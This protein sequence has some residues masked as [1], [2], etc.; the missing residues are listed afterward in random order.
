MLGMFRNSIEAN[1]SLVAGGV[2]VRRKL[3]YLLDTMGAVSRR[4]W[5]GVS[6]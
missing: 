4:S 6:F 1:V 5:V 2:C 3:E